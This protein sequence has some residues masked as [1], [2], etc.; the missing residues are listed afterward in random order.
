MFRGPNGAG[1]AP[2]AHPPARLGPEEN[3]AWSVPVPASPSSPAVWGER[4]FLTT[5]AEGKLEV[6]AFDTRDGHVLWATA[7]P[8]GSLE[9][10][11][12]TEGSPAASTPATD[13]RRVVSYF[14][15][16]G[17]VCHDLDGKEQ[18]RL[19]LPKATTAGN[20]GSGTSPLIVGNRVILNRDLAVGSSILGVD[21]TSGKTLWETPRTESPT[22]YGTPIVREQGGTTEII[23][24]GSI[25]MKGYDP[26]TGAERWRFRG[27][28]SY[29][30]TTPVLGDGLIFFAGWSPGKADAPMPTWAGVAE[31]MDKN[32]DGVVSPDEFT[33]G[34][35]WFK[36][37]DI[38]GDGLLEQSDWD[39]IIGL[40]KRGENVLVAVR[41]GGSG[42][43]SETHAVWKYTRGLPYVPSPLHYDGR[44]YLVRDGGMA[45]SLDA[46]TGAPI[47]AQERLKNAAGSYYASPVAADGRLYFLS[48]EGKLTIVKAGGDAPEILH[49]ADFKEKTAATPALAGKRLFLRTPTRLIAFAER[50]VAGTS[51]P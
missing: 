20:F 38:D 14:G 50:D 21:L 19:P 5:F 13:G 47:Y 44:I 17:L 42:D 29:T 6:R 51:A 22:S 9:E 46:K 45:T 23:M 24:A 32:H 33:D 1:I 12:L 16:F 34:P 18:W 27:L 25:F 43:V 3:V 31:R 37:Q 49:Q 7:V 28:P 36:A 30:C 26:A 35:A 11:H 41:P 2:G 39:Q 40:M 8:S 15:S 10:F 48:L 4:L